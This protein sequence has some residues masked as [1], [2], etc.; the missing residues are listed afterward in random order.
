MASVAVAAAALGAL[1]VLVPV[2]DNLP[3]S[4]WAWLKKGYQTATSFCRKIAAEK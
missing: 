3:H 2:Q 1:S 4:L